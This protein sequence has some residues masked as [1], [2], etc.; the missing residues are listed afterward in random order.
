MPQDTTPSLAAYNLPM[1]ELTRTVRFALNDHS[2][3][4]SH[5][6]E[7]PRDNTFAAWPAMRG[8]A[9]YYELD[10]TCHGEADPVTG[11]FIN[12]AHI[13]AAVRGHV[14][15][16]L[17]ETIR[18]QPGQSDQTLMGKLCRDMLDL[19]QP[20]LNNSVAALRLRLAPTLAI[21][22]ERDAMDSVLLTQR[23]EFSA[24]H[25]LHVETFS[26]EENRDVFGKCNNPAGHG[27]NYQIEVVVKVP[28]DT[29][30]RVMD[31]ETLDAVVDRE[32]IQRWD[33]KNLNC[34]VPEFE[35]TNS[36]VENISRIAFGHLKQPIATMGQ[37]VSLAS[38][39]VWETGKTVCTFAGA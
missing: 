38:V 23:Y 4:A 10:V 31:V 26:D 7:T 29:Q 1:L 20:Q 12:I 36:S 17:H 14:L 15:P 30:G 33:H 27:H 2:V 6:L 39:S 3:D 21:A 8:L 16:Y 13:D 22:I 24:A 32:L 19:L 28:I 9:R 18:T 25:R 34:D 11:Y 5:P 37:G 35:H